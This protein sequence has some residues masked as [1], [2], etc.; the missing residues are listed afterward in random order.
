MF[1]RCSAGGLGVL[2]GL[3][4]LE[5]M[6][7]SDSVFAEG[8]NDLIFGTVYIPN[9]V[10]QRGKGWFPPNRNSTTDWNFNNSAFDKL[11]PNIKKY[12]TVIENIENRGGRGNAHMQAISQF[13]TGLPIP[14]DRVTEH[15]KGQGSLTVYLSEEI[16]K[17]QSRTY[18][19][20]YLL[21]AANNE[22]DKPNNNNYNNK[23]KNSL[24]FSK[25]GR[26]LN[27]DRRA[28]LKAV[29]ENLFSGSDENA[30]N[31][32]AA[33]R[34][35]FKKS[36]LDAVQE[37]AQRLNRQLGAADKI[38]V[39]EYFAR[40]RNIEKSLEEE[41][42]APPSEGSSCNGADSLTVSEFSDSDRL[43][44]LDKHSSQTVELVTLALQ[45]GVTPGFSYMLGGEAAGCHYR[46]I[47][48]NKHCHNTVS[49]NGSDGNRDYEEINAYDLQIFQKFVKS[50]AS[51]EFGGK[52]MLEKGLF[53][54][55]G[56][57]AEGYNHSLKNIPVV[58]AGHGNGRVQ[59]G[60]YLK[61]NNDKRA[62]SVML[63][64]FIRAL[65]GSNLKIGDNENGNDFLS[66]LS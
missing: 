36:I 49:H 5:I 21:L 47:N 37:D 4:F 57:L 41:G 8:P 12:L 14:N 42:T 17:M 31:Q 64:T 29:F 23:L 20:P 51:T 53:L 43:N 48:I 1:L 50:F 52:T 40:V 19:S 65:T 7:T 35:F 59:G 10:K 22:L 63:T 55:G 2:V 9:G 6:A 54:F 56:G 27:D 26:L 34:R 13:L 44:R 38:R 30:T 60:R 11:D 66:D 16:A 33:R 28:N 58:W 15:A 39:D 25:N 3:P 62:T 45:C 18:K 61:V 46:E 24:D 32:E